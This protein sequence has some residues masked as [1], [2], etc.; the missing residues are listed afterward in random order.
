MPF[1]RPMAEKIGSFYTST[2]TEKYTYI[3]DIYESF[4]RPHIS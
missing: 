1:L 3:F 4:E 2:E